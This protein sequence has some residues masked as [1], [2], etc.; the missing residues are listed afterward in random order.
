MH[1]LFLQ[2][3]DARYLASFDGA[4]A[5]VDGQPLIHLLNRMGCDTD[6]THRATAVD[7]VHPILRAAAADGKRVFVIGQEEMVLLQAISRLRSQHRML[8][9]SGHHG[10]FDTEGDDATHVVAAA[11]D[12]GADLVLVGLGS[13]KSEVWIDQNRDRF[14][15]SVVWACGALMEYVA[16]AVPTPPRWSGQ[17]GIEWL[18]RLAHDPRR[19]LTRYFVEPVAL[20]ARVTARK[21]LR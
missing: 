12:F 3:K 21:I 16:G 8:E 17:L 2:S 18:F 19:F 10:F 20:L 1:T 4:I 15:A 13:P 9:I 14:D 6:H 7:L 11:N 5:L